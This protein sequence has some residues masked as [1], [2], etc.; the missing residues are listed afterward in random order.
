VFHFTANLKPYTFLERPPP[1]RFDAYLLS[2]D[3]AAGLS[4]LADQVRNDGRVLVADNG[5][6]DLLRE[7]QRRFQARAA[8]LDTARR[9]WE[10]QLGHYARPRELPQELRSQYAALAREIAAASP[11]PTRHTREEPSSARL[12]WTPRSSSAWRI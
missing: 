5:N 7:L 6:V 4:D 1:E 10:K 12:R 11:Q 9:A 3:Y 8:P 2:A